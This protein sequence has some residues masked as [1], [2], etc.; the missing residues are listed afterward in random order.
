MNGNL[1]TGSLVQLCAVNSV[2]DAE[3]FS[4]W[5]RDSEFMRLSDASP[6][7]MWTIKQTTEFIE[8][9][10]ET[11]SPTM[12]AFSIWTREDNRIVGEIDLSGINWASGESIVG[13]SIGD[14]NDWGK[15][16]GTDAMRVI[17]RFAFDELNLH[18]VFLNTF[19]YNPRAIRS[20][21]KCGFKHEGRQ[22][23]V[24]NRDGKRWD[25]LYMGILREEWEKLES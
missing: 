2:S 16:Y 6:A 5:S 11:E 17:L 15:G 24:L 22:R 7:Q 25:I 8:K 1:L 19:E 21:E 12:F 9:E 13:I 3:P 23:R 10:F 4:R 20:Y 18:R 14:R